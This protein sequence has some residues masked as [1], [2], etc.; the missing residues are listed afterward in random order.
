MVQNL[1]NLST[2]FKYNGLSN[3][4]IIINYNKVFKYIKLSNKTKTINY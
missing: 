3:Q 4:K 1:I 2:N